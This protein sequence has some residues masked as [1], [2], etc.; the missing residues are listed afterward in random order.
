MDIKNSS[1]GILNFELSNFDKMDK[2]EIKDDFFIYNS[3]PS[4]IY[5][6]QS[7]LHSFFRIKPQHVLVSMSLI[8]IYLCYFMSR[9]LEIASLHNQTNW[10][11]KDLQ[12]QTWTLTLTNNQLAIF[13]RQIDV[14]S[15]VL[16]FQRIEDT[17]NFAVVP[18]NKSTVSCMRVQKKLSCWQG[19]MRDLVRPL[20]VLAALKS[21]SNPMFWK[22]RKEVNL[23]ED[24]SRL[25][26][27]HK[28]F[29]T[30]SIVK[31]QNDDNIAEVSL[32]QFSGKRIE[33]K[34]R[35]TQDF[36]IIED[37]D[38]KNIEKSIQERKLS[39]L[40]GMGSEKIEHVPEIPQVLLECDRFIFWTFCEPSV[41]S[42]P[43]DKL[44]NL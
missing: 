27:Y 41:I 32:N 26:Y 31:D 39:P 36:S 9:P 3:H 23:G 24:G 22:S 21:S 37:K 18:K 12:N 29:Q 17:A 28:D 16:V 42:E 40:F 14:Q 33:I 15:E 4:S 7:L 8:L 5:R 30:I 20:T 10:M 2:N 44:R 6:I 1:S 38:L 35:K 25:D 43:F 13:Q 11:I 34:R 19:E